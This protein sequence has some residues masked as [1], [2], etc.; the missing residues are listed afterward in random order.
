M[1]VI[2]CVDC[3]Y[4]RNAVMA[5]GG[6][7]DS[8]TLGDE[9]AI[10]TEKAARKLRHADMPVQLVDAIRS[11]AQV[12]DVGVGTRAIEPREHLGDGIVDDSAGVVLHAEAVLLAKVAR[13]MTIGDGFAQRLAE[14]QI[15][16][17][18]HALGQLGDVNI[19]RVPGPHS[20]R[21]PIRQHGR[22]AVERR[23]KDRPRCRS[24]DETAAG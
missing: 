15:S 16:S 2:L 23:N 4:L 5:K 1:I 18:R 22:H 24:Q 8:A 7:R 10:A 19:G 21:P 11:C 9:I 3:A 14:R 20:G 6:W 17:I 13:R 12:L